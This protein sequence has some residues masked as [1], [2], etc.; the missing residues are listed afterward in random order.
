M[1]K[2]ILLVL[3]VQYN[4]FAVYLSLKYITVFKYQC[5]QTALNENDVDNK[6][7]VNGWLFQSKQAACSVRLTT[8]GCDRCHRKYSL[9]KSR[10]NLVV[11]TI[12]RHHLPYVALAAQYRVAGA[13]LEARHFLDA[14]LRIVA[15]VYLIRQ[16]FRQLL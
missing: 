12:C 16:S 3:F 13:P 15:L 8:C 4:Y 2:Q 6:T 9:W 7:S 5:K 10:S 11:V 1:C 14:S